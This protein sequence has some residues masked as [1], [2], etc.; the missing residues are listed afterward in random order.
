MQ[1]KI[2][3]SILLSSLCLAP[4]FAA[5]TPSYIAT[6]AINAPILD[7]AYN[8]SKMVAVGDRGH[9]L[10]LIDG[11]WQQLATPSQALLTAVTFV[12]KKGWAV[13]H[14][15]TILVT[16]DGGFTWAVAQTLP[17]LDKPLLDVIALSQ[18]NIIAIGAY[19]LTF[20]SHDGGATWTQDFFE[21]LLYEEDIEYLNELKE[22][23]EALYLDE[24][25]A[26]LPHFNRI[27]P[28]RN[29]DLIIVG[30]MGLVAKSVDAGKTWLTEESFYEGSLFDLVETKKGTLIATGLRGNIFRSTDAGQNW[31][32]IETDVTTTINSVVQLKSGEI[33][34]VANSG[35]ML[36]SKD[37]GRSFVTD[38]VAKGEDLVSVAQQ[39][40]GNILIAGSAGV[41]SIGL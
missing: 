20:R 33:V 17:E 10:A 13:G 15:A 8:G 18:D 11:K 31:E 37:D 6:K 35:Y 24:R 21:S 25:S 41:R 29:G 16:E 22:E 14:D 5:D 34:M 26:M 1:A 23:D 3:T 40:D 36:I 38:I 7:M 27:V 28:L 9:L 30:E 12:G 2:I 19:G 39:R 32:Q 4:S